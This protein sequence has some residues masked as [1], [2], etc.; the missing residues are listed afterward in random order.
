MK[1]SKTL[2]FLIILFSLSQLRAQETIEEIIADEY[3]PAYCSCLEENKDASA[4]QL[5]TTVSLKCGL[6]FAMKNFKKLQEVIEEKF[7]DMTKDEQYEA[8]KLLGGEIKIRAAVRI[9]KECEA[10]RKALI[11]YKKELSEN[12]DKPDIK[13]EITRLNQQLASGSKRLKAETYLT[14]GALLEKAGDDKG[15][16]EAYAKSDK[17]NPSAIARGFKVLLEMKAN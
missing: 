3:I 10:H 12:T 11:A 14:I 8:G 5:L 15:A 7:P 17:A 4:K 9:V 1:L 13:E 6:Q 16:I 2:T